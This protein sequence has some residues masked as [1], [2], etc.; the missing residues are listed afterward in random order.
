VMSGAVEEGM[1]HLDRGQTLCEPLALGTIWVECATLLAAAHAQ[2]GEWD[3]AEESIATARRVWTQQDLRDVKTTTMLMSGV[4]AF[5]HARSRMN[6]QA[7]ADIARAEAVLGGVSPV[8]PWAAVL[9][10]LFVARAQVLLEGRQAAVA[11]ARHARQV[12]DQTPPSPFLEDLAESAGHAIVASDELGRLTQAELRV[13]PMLLDRL[14]REEIAT[15]LHIS[16][17]TVKSH[18]ASI[19]RKLGV[20]TRRQLLDL[21]AA[22]GWAD[23]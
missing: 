17:A 3:E 6:S 5:M 15:Q 20:A 18:V 4:S 19:Y 12:L 11:S 22:H 10:E 2:R 8:V 21:A 1:A 9:V 16:Q 14:T 23:R 13:W 7:R